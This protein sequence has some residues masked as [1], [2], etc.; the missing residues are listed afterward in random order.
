MTRILDRVWAGTA[1]KWPISKSVSIP[2]QHHPYP[3][4]APL[5]PDAQLITA[6][7]PWVSWVL[8][9]IWWCHVL[10]YSLFSIYDHL[11]LSCMLI[12][13]LDE[14]Y[15]WKIFFSYCSFLILRVM[16]PGRKPTLPPKFTEDHGWR[17]QVKKREECGKKDKV[18]T[19]FYFL[20][21]F[22]Y[23]NSFSHFGTFL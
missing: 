6:L 9:S 11:L 23:F 5:C 7:M 13:M 14:T 19:V 17:S 18:F 10:G 1:R 2:S 12:E 3:A 4:I 15:V 21:V 16:A 22:F 20:V 8:S